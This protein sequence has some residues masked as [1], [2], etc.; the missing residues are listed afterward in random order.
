MK[1]KKILIMGIAILGLGAV[2]SFKV[3]A[4]SDYF[5]HGPITYHTPKSWRGTYHNSYGDTMKV[6]KY[7]VSYNGKTFYKSSWNG[8]RKLAIAKVDRNYY[9]LNAIAKYGY[10]SSR[11]WKLIHKNGNTYLYN[12]GAM[13]SHTT[14]KKYVKSK[15][16][17]PK[18]FKI[19]KTADNDDFFY[20]VYRSAY[21][22]IYSD[23]VELY[24]NKND[25]L[26]KTN[27][28]DLVITNHQKKMFAK[29]P[30]KTVYNDVINIKVDGKVYYTDNKS[31]AIKPFNAS[32]A[33]DS[34]IFSNF[35]PKSK[36]IVLKKGNHIYKG[37]EWT[38]FDENDNMINYVF[39]GKHWVKY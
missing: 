14:W 39:N 19:Y 6:N 31:K 7:S 16:I 2:S 3:A 13:E 15:K 17:K 26:E 28:P 1:L 37:T 25:A 8:W 10:Q 36:N 23:E 30:A 21:L 34:G 24:L 35:N 38:Y 18:T 20:D 27:D 33:G 29:W 22:N 4:S 11:R 12:K 5:V 9:T 32:R